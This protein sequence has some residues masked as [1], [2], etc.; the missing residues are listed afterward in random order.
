MPM[1]QLTIVVDCN[2]PQ[3]TQEICAAFALFPEVKAVLPEDPAAREAQYA[4]C[5]FPDPQLLARSPELK[6]IQAASA[7]V[8][9]LPA[10]VFASDVP[11]CRV[12]DEDFRHGMFEYALWGVLWF[13]RSFDRAL[14]HQRERTWKIYPQRA[15]ADYHVGVMGLGEIGGYIAAQLAGLGYK[16]SG[17]ARSEKSLAGVRC[18]H[19]DAQAGE[20]LGQLDALINVLPLTEQTR[21]ILAHPLLDQLPDGAALINCGRGEHMVNQD[22]LEAL[23]NGKLSGAVLD[24][25]PVEPLPQEDP[26]WQHPQVVIT[27]HMASIAQTVVVA[28]QLL[29]NIQRLH[30]AL[31]LKNLVN[32]QSGY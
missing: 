28:R 17:W 22:V 15:A 16:V 29:D 1:T 18:Y 6:L 2:D 25:F 12:V 4:S 8:D 30:Q 32:K 19:G 24:V 3:Y 9:H 27:P 31:P 14:A 10:S 20:F 23:E 13:Q 5:W 21:G 7:G 11:L 26:L